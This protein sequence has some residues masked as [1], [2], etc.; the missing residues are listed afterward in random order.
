MSQ[1]KVSLAPLLVL[2]A[3]ILVAVVLL[4]RDDTESS[5]AAAMDVAIRQGGESEIA[6]PVDQAS[7]AEEAA[8]NEF[9]SEP[10]EPEAELSGDIEPVAMA[11]SVDYSWFEGAAGFQRGVEEAQREGKALVVYF[12]TDWCPYCRELEGELLGR[13]GVEDFL[14]HLVKIRI[15]PEAG[16]YERAIADRYGVRGY[17]SFFVQP[18]ITDRPQKIRRTTGDRLKSPEEFVATLRQAAGL[19]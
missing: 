8:V 18:G 19:G 14:K 7:P 1:L 6:P 13:A 9:W 10:L 2:V 4:D 3:L 16:P 11:A 12:Y 5:T 15:N 17:P